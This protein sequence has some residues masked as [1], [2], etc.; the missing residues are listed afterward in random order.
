MLPLLRVRPAAARVEEEEAAVPWAEA[1]TTPEHSPRQQWSDAG[2]TPELP[3]AGGVA[4]LHV[5]AAAPS[6]GAIHGPLMTSTTEACITPDQSPRRW[7]DPAP[8]LE[9]AGAGGAMALNA[10]A[11]GGPLMAPCSVEAHFVFASKMRLLEPNGLGLDI[12]GPLIIGAQEYIIVQRI[13]LGGAI[14]AWNW[15]CDRC[16]NQLQTIYEGDIMVVGGLLTFEDQMAALRKA[17]KDESV[18]QLM[19]FRLQW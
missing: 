6:A 19:V 18:V 17:K 2:S 16:N 3:V 10:G 5:G 7:S 4:A 8:A 1:Y 15:T 14:N 12:C 11:C 9:L 13:H